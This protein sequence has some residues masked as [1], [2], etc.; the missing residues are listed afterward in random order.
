MVRTPKQRT[1]PKAKAHTVDRELANA[2]RAE[3]ERLKLADEL[4]NANTVNGHCES[5]KGYRTGHPGWG[6]CSTHGGNTEAGRKFAAREA[7]HALIQQYKTNH[8]RFG[9]DRQDP[10]IAS[11]TPEQ[12]LLEEVRRSAAM[13]RFLEERI[14]AWGLDTVQQTSL[15][16]YLLLPAGKAGNPPDVKAFL[17]GLDHEDPDSPQHLPDLIQVDERTGLSSFTNRREWLQLY[18]E[19]RQHLVRTAKMT[20]DAGVAQRIVSIAEDQGRILA[21]AIRAVLAALGLSPSQAALVPQVVPPI[22]RAV[23][24]DQPVPDITTL[25]KVEAS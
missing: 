5:A 24:S 1:G 13:V 18:R 17:D 15:E 19:E 22:L 6:R 21:A 8:L 10:T 3:S 9:G 25:L 16:H 14:A 12:V 23:A 20:I 7:G 4:C 2:T 11:L